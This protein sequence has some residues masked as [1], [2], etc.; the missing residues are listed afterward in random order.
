MAFS[1]AWGSPAPF[2]LSARGGEEERGRETGR[3]REKRGREGGERRR[4][5]KKP[6]FGEFC[7]VGEPPV[8]I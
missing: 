5:G 4:K 7:E 1:T 8:M 2:I 3:K 6:T